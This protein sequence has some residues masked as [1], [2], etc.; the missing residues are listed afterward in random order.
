MQRLLLS[1]RL[2][3]L[4]VWQSRDWLRKPKE[5]EHVVENRGGDDDDDDDDDDAPPDGP[6]KAVH[7]EPPQAEGGE[8]SPIFSLAPT[9][10]ER[11]RFFSAAFLRSFS[12]FHFRPLTTCHQRGVGYNTTCHQRGV[13][14]QTFFPKNRARRSPFFF[15]GGCPPTQP[16][17]HP[18]RGRNARDFFFGAGAMPLHPQSSAKET[19]NR[20]NQYSKL[21]NSIIL[22][23]LSER[24][25]GNGVDAKP[26]PCRHRGAAQMQV[27]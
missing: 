23:I 14:F 13:E 1:R 25:Q 3:A 11:S 2:V 9:R 15:L 5:V 7:L 10:G 6:P 12:R 18:K 20:K 27:R 8:R 19:T 24:D 4:H 21:I 16:K 17:I 26:A 22:L